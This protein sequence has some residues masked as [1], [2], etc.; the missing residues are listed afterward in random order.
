MGC[1]VGHS[2]E[3][4]LSP[5]VYR[6]LHLGMPHGSSA[7]AR[8]IAHGAWHGIV[9]LTGFPRHTMVSYLVPHGV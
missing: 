9:Y 3:E 6:A 8:G 2:M 7:V 4:H 5:G 1:P